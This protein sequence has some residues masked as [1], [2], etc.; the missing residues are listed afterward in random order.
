MLTHVPAH[1]QRADGHRPYPGA[2][3]GERSALGLRPDVHQ[4]GVHYLPVSARNTRAAARTA[5]APWPP[6][7]YSTSRC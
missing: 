5:A 7:A 4:L 3:P 2:L 6:T 1:Q